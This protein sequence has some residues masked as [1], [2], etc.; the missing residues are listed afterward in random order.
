M[1]VHAA[2]ADL[3]AEV[4][5]TRRMLA[6]FPDAH[7]AYTPHAKSRSLAEL[8]T[9]VATIPMLGV[10]VLTAEF[11]DV[12]TRAPL[13]PATTAADLVRRFEDSVAPMLAAL[14]AVDAAALDQTWSL[15]AGDKVLRGGPRAGMFRVMTLSHLIHHR[16]QLSVYYRLVGSPVPGMYGPSADDAIPA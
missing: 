15:R 1:P 11:R 5:A 14:D 12:T 8:A 6:A 3:P 2:F 9:H 16:A 4:A 13:I 7:A 10:S